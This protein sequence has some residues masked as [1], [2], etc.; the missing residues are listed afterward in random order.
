MKTDITRVEQK[1]ILT[2]AP[3]GLAAAVLAQL[4]LFYGIPNAKIF[5]DIVF[6][7][8][9]TSIMITIAG[10]LMSG[11]QCENKVNDKNPDHTCE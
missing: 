9:L 8:I 4:P 11:K 5:S 1:F 7:I 2:M 3:R 10:V 6:V